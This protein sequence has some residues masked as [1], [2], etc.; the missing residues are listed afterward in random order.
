MANTRNLSLSPNPI[1]TV[2][3]SLTTAFE[4]FAGL[5]KDDTQREAAVALTPIA[6]LVFVLI[7]RNCKK[8]YEFYRGKKCYKNMI[9]ELRVEIATPGIST[10]RK[11]KLQAQIDKHQETLHQMRQD[12][13]KVIVR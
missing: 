1:T 4:I 6:V 10:Q 11:D 13:I 12:N 5:L 3:T 9:A 7:A 2:I 8:E